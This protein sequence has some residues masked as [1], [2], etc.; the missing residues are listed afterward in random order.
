MLLR[1][2]SESKIFYTGQN[3][4]RSCVSL[5][6]NP[7]RA[8]ARM[9]AG[10]FCKLP[11]KSP[12]RKPVA[13]EKVT[14]SPRALA[15]MWKDTHRCTWAYG[16]MLEWYIP[17]AEN[18]HVVTSRPQPIH[19]HISSWAII[20]YRVLRWHTISFMLTIHTKCI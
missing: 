13:Y 10:W 8:T 11:L 16:G 7:W 4:C 1:A 6:L 9:N 12:A 3:E 5:C 19:Q 2:G 15:T 14:F 18:L 17:R 20:H